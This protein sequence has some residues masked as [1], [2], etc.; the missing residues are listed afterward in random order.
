MDPVTH[1]IVGT[2]MAETGLRQRYGRQATLALA[3]GGFLA[4]GVL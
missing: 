3:G 4:A 2:L 1:G